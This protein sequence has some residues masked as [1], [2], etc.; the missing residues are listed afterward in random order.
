MVLPGPGPLL[1]VGI[2][3]ISTIVDCICVYVCLSVAL[4]VVDDNCDVAV[5]IASI[6]VV[7]AIRLLASTQ[8]GC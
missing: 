1:S 6:A 2:L 4:Y 7:I 8:P 3:S 5:D